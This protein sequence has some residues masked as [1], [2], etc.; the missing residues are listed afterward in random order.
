MSRLIACS[1]LALLSTAACRAQECQPFWT[2]TAATSGSNIK[3][4]VAYDAGDGTAIYVIGGWGGYPVYPDPVRRWNGQ[5]F[6]IAGLRLSGD[7]TGLYALDD[8]FGPRLHF[9]KITANGGQALFRWPGTSW[10]LI[11][12][13]LFVSHSPFTGPYIC[14]RFSTREGNIAGMYGVYW[15]PGVRRSV[16]RWTG[17]FWRTIG[18][19][20]TSESLNI[21]T[22]FDPG[23]GPNLLVAGGFQAISGVA[24]PYLARWD[25]A[26]W[27]AMGQPPRAPEVATV[28]DD[29]T[30]PSLYIGFAGGTSGEQLQREGIARWTGSGWVSVGGG[31]KADA[32]GYGRVQGMA[33]FDDGTGPALFVTGAFDTAGSTPARNIAKWDGSQWHALGAGVGGFPTQLAVADDGRGSSLFVLGVPMNTCGGG[34]V[35]NIAQWVGCAGNRQCYADCD[36]NRNL[37]ANDF[38]CFMTKY[39]AKDPYANCDVSTQAPAINAADFA[40]FLTKFAAGC[41]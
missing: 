19:V 16:A 14:P 5:T 29:G 36:N 30:G 41:P 8:G 21:L 40:C 7:S 34:T 4:M 28:W 2:G 15:V 13:G 11:H 24:A 37:N 6:T 1:T 39:A 18:E 33:V 38:A 31:I 12:T 10:E 17:A 23:T 22:V 20:P 9:V 32:L 26:N 27:H 35:Y 25:G 3:S